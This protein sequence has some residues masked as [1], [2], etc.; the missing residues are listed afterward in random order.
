MGVAWLALYAKFLSLF[1][2][3]LTQPKV[4]RWMERATGAVLI[5]FGVR[6]ASSTE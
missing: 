5:A 2:R 6:V 1:K 3:V 4:K